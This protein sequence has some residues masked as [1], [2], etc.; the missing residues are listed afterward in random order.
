MNGFFFLH[1]QNG[2]ITGNESEEVTANEDEDPLKMDTVIDL[3][4]SSSSSGETP[5]PFVA[6]DFKSPTQN[7]SATSSSS[8]KK[9]VQQIVRARPF[10]QL[11]KVMYLT[12]STS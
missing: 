6:P 12:I 2:T 11:A 3:A 4:E 9:Q 7:K 8:K 10:R 5:K 1:P